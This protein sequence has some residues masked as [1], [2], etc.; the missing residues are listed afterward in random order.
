VTEPHEDGR[1]VRE[2]VADHLRSGGVAQ[3]EADRQAESSYRRELE[4][5]ERDARRGPSTDRQSRDR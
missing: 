1:L 4:R 2:R 3:G 5:M